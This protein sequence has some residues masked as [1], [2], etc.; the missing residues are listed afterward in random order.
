MNKRNKRKVIR[1]IEAMLD[2]ENAAVHLSRHRAA[3]P[4]ALGVNEWLLTGDRNYWKAR[5]G[6]DTGA[7]N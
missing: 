4:P 1:A 5:R 2:R 3:N 6:L 7:A